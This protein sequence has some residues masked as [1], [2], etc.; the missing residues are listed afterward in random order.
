[1][2]NLTITVDE[3]TLKQARIKAVQN[4]TTVNRVLA[5]YLA[6][7]AAGEASPSRTV[8][9]I[10]GRADKLKLRSD[11]GRS[12]KRDEIYDRRR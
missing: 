1:M 11:D 2:A 9:K 10:V 8:R 7:Y 12:L 4:D 5:D 6:R 3:A